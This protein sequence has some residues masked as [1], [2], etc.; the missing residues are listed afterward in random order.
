MFG[1]QGAPHVVARRIG[2]TTVRL[3]LT[4]VVIRQSSVP[5]FP[6]GQS[7]TQ[8]ESV[9]QLAVHDPLVQVISHSLFAPHVIIP[10]ATCASQRGFCPWQLT[11]QG[12]DS[13]SKEHAAPDAQVHAP[14]AH[15]PLQVAIAPQVTSQGGASHSSSQAPRSPH[16]QSPSAQAPVQVA[17][18]SQATSQGGAAHVKSQRASSP[19][20][21]SAPAHAPVHDGFAPSQLSAHGG[22]SQEAS[23]LAPTG[24]TQ[25]PSRSHA[26]PAE[27]P[28][29]NT[30]ATM[31][32]A[33]MGPSIDRPGARAQPGASTSPRRPRRGRQR[34]GTRMA[35]RGVSEES[36]DILRL[37]A[38]II[39]PPLG[40]FLQ[41]GLHKRFWIN[42]LLTLLGYVPGVVH[43]V[44][45]IARH[46]PRRLPRAPRTA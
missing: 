32:M 45:V 17:P 19:Q 20:V 6:S 22:D 30:T 3:G 31:E 38:A 35:P 34:D 15:S 10:P 16:A 46:E 43:A 23:Q 21:H 44:W 26:K 36:M 18:A 25:V 5:A 4:Q 12:G 27:Q 28:A 37:I 11:A 33:L 14:S 7:S 8:L 1:G 29:K 9:R 13:H 2:Q 41:E 42:V 24:H 39:L 40:V